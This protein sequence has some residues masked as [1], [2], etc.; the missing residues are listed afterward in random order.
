M[1]PL[2]L[3]LVRNNV[4]TL[5][6]MVE[7]ISLA[8]ARNLGLEAGTLAKGAPADIAIFDPQ[9]E[10]ELDPAA[11]ASKSQNTPFGGWTKQ[12]AKLDEVSGITGWTLHDLRRTVATNLAVLDV[13]PHVAEAVLNHSSGIVSGIA[14]VYNRHTYQQQK[15]QAL[16]VWSRQLSA[17]IDREPDGSNVLPFQ[18]S[19]HPTA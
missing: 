19:G 2:T 4:I 10:W 3:D 18:A 16:A 11:M 15:T 17:I 6:R 12:K 9:R 8:P 1:L 5:K 7:A 14:A 13:A